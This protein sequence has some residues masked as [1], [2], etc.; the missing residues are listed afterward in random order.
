[1][2][3]KK[4]DWEL[5]DSRID[6]KYNLFSVSVNRNKSPRTG[7]IH[8]FQTLTSP[9]WVAVIAV[10]PKNEMVMV[11]QYRHG[12][13]GVSLEPPGGLVKEGQNAEQSGREELEEET[14]YVAQKFEELGWM[15]PV[16]AIFTNKF[17]V[18]L[19]ENAELLGAK[20]PDETEEIETVLVPVGE[21]DRM[22]RGGE[23]NASVMIA[24]L[25][26]YSIK[27]RK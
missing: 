22:I 17:Y 14:G 19:A 23:I 12:I 5:V 15:Y 21:I 7:K 16:P 18:F 11:K 26:L 3:S 24:A 10:T 27:K 1:M 2:G 9:D 8:Q 20:N 13:A 25:N 4:L 6:R